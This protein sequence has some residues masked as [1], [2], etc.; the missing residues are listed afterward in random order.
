MRE[1]EITFKDGTTKRIEAKAYGWPQ[2]RG[3]YILYLYGEDRETIAMYNIKKIAAIYDV[4]I[5]NASLAPYLYH[6]DGD[7]SSE[8]RLHV[9]HTSKVSPNNNIDIF[10]EENGIKMG[11]INLD[12]INGINIQ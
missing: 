2:R 12:N 9:H 5:L 4:T 11:T 6:L 7:W 10:L 1:F 3:N 8:T